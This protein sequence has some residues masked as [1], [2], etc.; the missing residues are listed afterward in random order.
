MSAPAR[1]AVVVALLVGVVAVH[2]FSLAHG[3]LFSRVWG[4]EAYN[5]TVAV[6]LA[7]GHGYASDG[8]LTSGRFDP[9]D[10]RVSTGPTVLLPIA[11]L[12]GFGLDAVTAGRVVMSLLY[13]GAVVGIGMLGWK[14][15][16]TAGLIIALAVP[17]AFDATNPDS[18]MQSPI[19]VIGEWPAAGL[20]AWALVVVERRP[21]LAGLL[22]GIA[23]QAKL[24]TVISIPVIIAM[25]LVSAGP[26]RDRIRKGLLVTVLAG[27]PTLVFEL[28]KVVQ[29][30]IPGY[31]RWFEEFLE[32]FLL[33]KSA[34][35]PL[36]KARALLD[37]WFIPSTWVVLMVG[38][39]ALAVTALAIK[40]RGVRAVVASVR[41]RPDYWLVA[42]CALL[43]VVWATWWFQSRAD[44]IWIRHLFP[45]FI[46]AAAGLLAG[47]WRAWEGLAAT[48]GKLDRVAGRV[49]A[50]T[51]A[52]ALTVSV[53]GRLWYVTHPPLPE[54]IGE[55][56]VVADQV[57]GVGGDELVGPWGSMPIAVL[58]GTHPVP[59]NLPSDPNSPVLL[60]R[61]E[62]GWED[63]A[64]CRV[65]LW[66]STDYRL[67]SRV[68]PE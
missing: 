39:I 19:D 12:I 6:N 21:W 50:G 22:L 34:F 14:I 47:A 65:E 17:L 66:A 18:P 59:L 29:L 56:R 64:L 55:Q 20:L 63:P 13:V 11:G 7:A 32:F 24:V 1:R 30:G 44:L 67:C 54:T 9:F 27:V 49:A 57:R 4:D 68:P 62:E 41:H 8:I 33:K 36:E 48:S 43:A 16:R 61:G 46:P 38:L 26:L 60:V 25:I 58:A 45:G 52:L 10:P 5:L 28:V 40:R 23:V 51:V 15:A 37:S 2:L 31:L 3:I 53:G 42:V 35:L